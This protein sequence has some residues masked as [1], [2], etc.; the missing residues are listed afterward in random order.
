MNHTLAIAIDGVEIGA[1]MSKRRKRPLLTVKIPNDEREFIIGSFDNNNDAEWF[2]FTL[3]KMYRN[4]K[5]GDSNCEIGLPE[6][7]S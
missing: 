2:L 5:N 1:V 3:S 7:I 4:V 6:I